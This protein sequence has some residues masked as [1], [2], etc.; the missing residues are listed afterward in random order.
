MTAP[1][2]F[3]LENATNEELAFWQRTLGDKDQN[4]GDFETAMQIM[5][6]H[7]A[8]NKTINFAK[9]YAKYCV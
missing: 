4:Q 8:Q 6:K 7:D 1:I 9:K 3:A 5:A 2:I